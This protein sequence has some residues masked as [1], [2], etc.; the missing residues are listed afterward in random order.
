MLESRQGDFGWFRCP[1]DADKSECDGL[2][3]IFEHI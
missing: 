1:R 2:E 3:L